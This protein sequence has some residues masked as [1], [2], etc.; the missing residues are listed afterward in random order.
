MRV[1]VHHHAPF[2]EYVRR[3]TALGIGAQPGV[4][5]PQWEP[6]DSLAMMDRLGIDLAVL[7]VG[8]PGFYFG[9]RDFTRDLC[10]VVNDALAGATAAQPDRFAAFAVVPLPSVDDSIAELDRVLSQPGFA[11]VG[12][13]TNYSDRYLGDPSFDPV[14]A[15]LDERAAVVH[16]HPTVPPH[17]PR[18]EI[19]LR[20]SVLEYLF[21]STRAMVNLI[22][23]GL[24]GR[25]PNIRWIFSHCG[26]TAPYIADRLALA[27]PMPELSAV[28]QGGVLAELRGFHY[29]TALCTTPYSLNVVR[30]LAGT[31]AMLLG[32]DFPFCAEE[33]ARHCLTEARAVLGEESW[34]A[35]TTT[36]PGRLFPAI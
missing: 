24:P 5:F 14:L 29:D 1:D 20:P 27:E 12:L 23:R 18:T 15:Y 7:S 9:D 17:Y 30:E 25:F 2:P 28:G 22:L 13:L 4:P 26:G 3:L 33:I 16:V 8:S 21:D 10:A 36:N 32:S 6:A 35:V 34:H 31:E 11:G 19:S